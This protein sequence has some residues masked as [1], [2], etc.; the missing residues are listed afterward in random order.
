VAFIGIQAQE[1]YHAYHELGLNLGAGVYGATFFILTGF[2]GLHV[3]LGTIM[4]MVMLG[5]YHER[6]FL[7]NTTTLPLR[8]WPGT[9][10]LWMWSG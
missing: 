5:P 4:L 10:T 9:G 3:T 8:R 2:H 7:R 1:Y 6:P